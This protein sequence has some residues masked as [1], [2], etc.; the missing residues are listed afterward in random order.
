MATAVLILLLLD[1][2]LIVAT[3]TKIMLMRDLFVDVLNSDVFGHDV[4]CL[5]FNHQLLLLAARI[6]DI[7]FDVQIGLRMCVDIKSRLML[8]LFLPLEG[9]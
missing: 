4:R 8:A 5:I 2:F 6:Q 9:V 1:D 7:V 3:I